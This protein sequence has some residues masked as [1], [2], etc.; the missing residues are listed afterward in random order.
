MSFHEP[1]GPAISGRRIDEV[2]LVSHTKS[3]VNPAATTP[4]R[5]LKSTLYNALSGPIPV[6]QDLKTVIEEDYPTLPILSALK[7]SCSMPQNE[8]VTSKFGSVHKGSVLGVQQKLNSEFLINVFDNVGFPNLPIQNVM[9]NEYC[10]VLDNDQ[11]VQLE[12]IKISYDECL[13]FEELTSSQS[14]NPLWHEIRANRLTASNIGRIRSRRDNFEKLSDDL[15]STRKVCTSA[16]KRGKAC[17]P[18]AAASYAVIKENSINLYPSGVIVNP[19]CPWLAASPDRK[20]Y[21]PTRQHEPFGLLEIK[22]PNV[23][24]VLEIK[25]GSIKRDKD[26]GQLYLNQNHMYYHQVQMQLAVTGLP[27]CDFFVWTENPKDYHLETV[28]FQKESWQIT[29]NKA[30]KLYFEYFL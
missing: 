27:W 5:E 6:L 11:T 25:D 9:V 1:R 7:A 18:L 24:S 13:Q 2:S 3:S 21:D 8:M 23:S 15:K 4:V 17:E 30:D 20:V 29:K 26:S 19:Y 14:E 16:M 12:A 28:R 22:C 10:P